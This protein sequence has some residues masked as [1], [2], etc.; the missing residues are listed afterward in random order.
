MTANEVLTFWFGDWDDTLP[1]VDDDPNT[2][3]WWSQASDTDRVVQD[4]FGALHTELVNEG[5]REWCDSPEELLACIIVLDQFSRVVYR[6]QREAFASDKRA[7]QLTERAIDLGW[8]T[9]R[10]PIERTFLYLPLV[11]AE[12]R[13]R[14]E[15][16]HG[17]LSA[18]IDEVAATGSPRSD[19]YRRVLRHAAEHKQI[20]DRFG[21]YPHRNLVLE[22]TS[23]PEELDYMKEH[24]IG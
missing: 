4:R 19:Y 3:R 7:Q 24:G 23:T 10:P 15:R 22:R 1:L 17:L 16:A 11:H 8:D 14:H 18:L 5:W 2:R 20:I 9:S 21:R 12:D 6:G 13:A